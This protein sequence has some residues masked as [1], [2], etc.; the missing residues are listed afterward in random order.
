[1]K[2]IIILIVVAIL[3]LGLGF[4][5]YICYNKFHTKEETKGELYEGYEFN[6]GK[7]SCAGKKNCAKKVKL[8]YNGKNHIIQVAL[9]SEVVD[10]SYYYYYN[11]YI[12]GKLVGSKL[13]GGDYETFDDYYDDFGG[14]IYVLNDKYLAF[15]KR[16]SM[17]MRGYSID[18][19]N[20]DKLVEKDIF[21]KST[22]ATY[23][24]KNVVSTDGNSIIFYRGKCDKRTDNDITRVFEKIELTFDGEKAT[25]KVIETVESSGLGGATL[26]ACN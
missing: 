14:Y 13:T 10:E 25:E 24:S 8:S 6:L 5:G 17:W 20:E 4:A 9:R 1:M 23:D 2:K 3:M 19:F 16:S 12:D 21:I 18:L 22:E 11:L 15:V 26:E 7:V